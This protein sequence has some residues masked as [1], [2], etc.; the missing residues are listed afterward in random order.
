MLFLT[1]DN[2]PMEASK[3]KEQNKEQK[4]DIR[5]TLSAKEASALISLNR[6]YLANKGMMDYVLITFIPD[7]TLRPFLTPTPG[8]DLN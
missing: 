5:P 1:G 4:T 3:Q 7:V 2:N 8:V 6:H